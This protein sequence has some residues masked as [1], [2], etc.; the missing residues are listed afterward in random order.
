MIEKYIPM[1]NIVCS[2]CA[3]V[4]RVKL[5]EEVRNCPNCKRNLKKIYA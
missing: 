4:I 1:T 5:T 2:F 3:T